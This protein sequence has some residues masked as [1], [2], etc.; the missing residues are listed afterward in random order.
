MDR[1]TILFNNIRKY[2]KNIYVYNSLTTSYLNDEYT[3]FLEKIYQE[4]SKIT[5]ELNSQIEILSKEITLIIKKI[6]YIASD[7]KS[8]SFEKIITIN[9]LSIKN[10]LL[11][12]E[13][14]YYKRKCIGQR[15]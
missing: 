4:Q 1:K 9:E 10:E 5:E 8:D 12:K 7:I 2:V 11:M 13:L 6:N 15:L 3:V 14:E